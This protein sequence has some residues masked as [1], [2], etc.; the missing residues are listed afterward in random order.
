M[1][2]RA[3]KYKKK[4]V[5]TSAIQFLLLRAILLMHNFYYTG[6]VI[7]LE[8]HGCT[9]GIGGLAQFLIT[10]ITKDNEFLLQL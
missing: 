6:Q 10:T 8:T 5:S 4:H 9:N 2:K 7:E 1:Y 3:A